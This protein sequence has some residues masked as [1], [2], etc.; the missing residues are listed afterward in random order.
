MNQGTKTLLIVVL[1][2]AAILGGGLFI[3]FLKMPQTMGIK[4]L[5]IACLLIAISSLFG[6]VKLGNIASFLKK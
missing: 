1:G 2:V 5:E 4:G 3:S 6:V